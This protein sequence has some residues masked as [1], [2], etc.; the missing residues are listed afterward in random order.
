MATPADMGMRHLCT[1]PV[2]GD[3]FI[4]EFQQL[5]QLSNSASRQWLASHRPLFGLTYQDG[6]EAAIGETSW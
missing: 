5:T 1:S 3:D 4:A 2:P 6:G